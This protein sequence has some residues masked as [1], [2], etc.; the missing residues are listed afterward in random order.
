MASTMDWKEA[1][2]TTPM[3]RSRALR[4]RAK[5]LNS[6]RK[7]MLKS[8]KGTVVHSDGYECDAG[9]SAGG[10]SDAGI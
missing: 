10:E 9:N 3:A 7:D 8:T 5:D 2:M 4:L 1:P 6:E